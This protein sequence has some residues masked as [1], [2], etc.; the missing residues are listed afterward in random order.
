MRQLLLLWASPNKQCHLATSCYL[1]TRQPQ[2]LLQA[3]CL[4]PNALPLKTQAA[5]L[6][7]QKSA[8][9]ITKLK[10]LKK[11]IQ[12]VTSTYV[13]CYYLR[14]RFAQSR[15]ELR[16][17]ISM[18]LQ[19]IR[20]KKMAAFCAERKRLKVPYILTIMAAAFCT[21]PDENEINKKATKQC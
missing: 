14:T 20:M 8:E 12:K 5:F 3:H 17:V 21:T 4:L 18:R 11:W 10:W 19:K 13:L 6:P 2:V 9:I 15:G 1:R 16:S 7:A